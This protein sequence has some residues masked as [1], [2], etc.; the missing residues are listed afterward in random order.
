MVIK[1]KLLLSCLT[2][3]VAVI[4]CCSFVYGIYGMVSTE[5]KNHFET[6]VVDIR[7]TEYQIKNGK[8][9]AFEDNPV[10]LPGDE[11]SKIPRIS[12]H[13]SDC[14]VRARIDIRPDGD[15]PA[16]AID[17]V[18]FSGMEDKWMKADDGY[19]YYTES[20][21]S[22]ESVDL[23]Q[24]VL[25]PADLP[26]SETEGGTFHVNI[27]V[28]AVQSKNFTP[29]FASAAPWGNI[30]ILRYEQ[31]GQYDVSTFKVSDKQSFTI[32]YL[33]GV[34]QMV[35]N[36]DDFFV[37]IPYLMPGDSYSDT[38]EIKNDGNNAVKLYFRSGKLDESELPEKIKLK[39]TT[40]IAGKQEIFYEGV[41]SASDLTE[42]KIL[43]E[44]PKNASGTFA[45]QIEVPAELNNQYAL[46]SSAVQWVF[47]TE[48]I[49]EIVPP[50]TGDSSNSGL[51]IGLI[52]V[53]AAAMIS[54]ILIVKKTRKK[55]EKHE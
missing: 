51:Y 15:M 7:F 42:D 26:Q 17:G 31:N 39:I 54:L 35:K 48:P 44:I 24:S 47:S 22:E 11:I 10:V 25:I 9:E 36:S 14:Y 20:L 3:F 13:G 29:E 23:F 2:C 19:Y 52:I 37:N 40:D 28:D 55:G 8:E 38:V 33:G 45:F 41:L 1:K 18:T 5:I 12:N 46:A 34:D 21:V 32:T 53:S 16:E 50:K 49:P 43:G 30:E 4:S 27:K 6:G